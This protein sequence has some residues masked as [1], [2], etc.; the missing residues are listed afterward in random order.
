V[1]AEIKIIY[2]QQPDWSQWGLL[3]S[4]RHLDHPDSDRD[5][6]RFHLEQASKSDLMS[7]HKVSGY[8]N[9]LVEDAAEFLEPYVDNLAVICQGNHETAPLKYTEYDLTQGLLYALATKGGTHIING[10]YR[11]WIS[12][13]FEHESGSQRCSRNLYYTHG[14]GGGGPVTKDVI[15]ASRKAVYLGNADYV[16]SGHTHD[17][18][19]FPIARI[20]LKASGQE[21]MIEQNHLKIPSYKDEFTNKG[22]GWHH[23]TGKP[24]KMPGAWWMRFYYSKRTG[25]I[26]TEFTRAER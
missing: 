25:E 6:Q 3:T 21:I 10:A 23:E 7:R 15:Q 4:D 9:S 26:E 14:Y 1:A 20:R 18:W 2:N 17:S 12:F 8:L 11:G 24:P 22:G 13:R 16:V 19:Q 5:L